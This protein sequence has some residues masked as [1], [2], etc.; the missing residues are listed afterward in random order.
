MSRKNSSSKLWAQDTL[1]RFAIRRANERIQST[2]RALPC[3][4]VSISGQIVTVTFEVVSDTWGL[5]PVK[6][7]IATSIYDFLPVQPGDK[8]ITVPGDVSLGLLS[9]LGT[10][11]P[12]L[13]QNP[14][15]LSSLV[16][17]PVANASWTPPQDANSR[18]MQGPN[19]FSCQSLDGSVKIV[20][21]KG[22]SLTVTALGYTIVVNS[23]G[24]TVTA[25]TITLN[26]NVVIS[27]TLSSG[28]SSGGAATFS[29][30]VSA[31]GTVSSSSDVTAGS[32][33]LTN[34]YHPGVTTGSG[35]TGTAEG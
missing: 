31:T 6:I 28:G 13:G 24:V 5:P 34:H 14:S 8:G 1:N 19:G 9:G 33:S 23:S 35:N 7:P 27:G 25:P 15:N 12:V 16:F 30:P 32:I 11:T 29:G 4:V 18:T 20:G 10:G 17:V 26:G 2:G 22:T 21:I 3:K